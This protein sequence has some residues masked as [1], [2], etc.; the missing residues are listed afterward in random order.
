MKTMVLKFVG[1]GC[2]VVLSSPLPRATAVSLNSLTIVLLN[3]VIWPICL[4]G[5]QEYL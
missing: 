1:C 4:F 5:T 3:T 2:Q